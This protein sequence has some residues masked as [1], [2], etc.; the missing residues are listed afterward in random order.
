KLASS[1]LSSQ[2]ISTTPRPPKPTKQLSSQHARNDSLP[3]AGQ[4]GQRT[5]KRN[6]ELRGAHRPLLVQRRLPPGGARGPPVQGVRTLVLGYRRHLHQQRE[7]REE[8]CGHHAG[9]PA[10]HQHHLLPRLLLFLQEEPAQE[11]PLHRLQRRQVQ[12]EEGHD[13]PRPG[14][15]ERDCGVTALSSAFPDRPFKSTGAPPFH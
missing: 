8:D 6:P 15:S 1:T 7:L 11:E 5:Q 10:A 14:E 12:G 13:I 4:T 9:H 3:R 2:G